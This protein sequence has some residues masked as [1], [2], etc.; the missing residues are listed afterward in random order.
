MSFQHCMA[1]P[2]K[3]AP[4]SPGQSSLEGSTVDA[5]SM[6]LA[7]REQ[8]GLNQWRSRGAANS[9]QRLHQTSPAV[10]RGHE[11]ARPKSEWK[12]RRAFLQTSDAYIFWVALWCSPVIR[13][14]RALELP[15]K[16]TS[17]TKHCSQ[18]VEK[19][20]PFPTRKTWTHAD[21]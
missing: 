2:T 8:K 13:A 18:T 7:R 6:P 1:Q 14:L 5:S 12:W 16:R 9:I 19:C 20:R 15:G 3:V 17:L 10:V 11:E 21:K 4:P